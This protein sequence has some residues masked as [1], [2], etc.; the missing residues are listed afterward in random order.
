MTALSDYM[1]APG[2]TAL[3]W[4]GMLA[5]FPWLQALADCPHDP[6]HH[7]EG[8]VLVHTRMVM[9]ALLAL[10]GYQAL[11]AEDRAC[12]FAA[13]LLHDVAKPATTRVNAD[14]R[15][16]Q[17]GHSRKGAIMARAILWRMGMDFALRERVCALIAWHQIPLF[18]IEKNPV[19]ARR[20]AIAISLTGRND[21]LALLA[22]A[23]A[24]GRICADPG[25]LLGNIA[26]FRTL[27]D[28]E[29]VLARP[30]VFPSDHTRIRFFEHDTAG[31]APDHPQHDDTRLTVHLLSGLPGAGKTSWLARHHPG[32]PVVGLDEIRRDFGVSHGEAE[33]RVVQEAKARARAHLRAGTDFAWSGTNIGTR[34]RSQWIS[35][36]R[37]YGARVRIVYVESA[38]ATLLRQNRA[39]AGR[40]PDAV[41]DRM[42][43]RWEVPDATEAHSI[44]P[45]LR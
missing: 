3:D 11:P 8:D 26:L 30:F 28:D 5:D 19:E 25:R 41:I 7:A 17:P 6:V 42:I 31:I 22:E 40:V 38:A 45:V 18:L 34:S 27:C 36:F 1:P 20:R 4:Q 13:A 12:V 23:D 35:L 10:D 33:G 9:E 24:R 16:S 44:H 37:S 39:R 15:V 2:D 14:G 29:G 21:L 43:S 32:L